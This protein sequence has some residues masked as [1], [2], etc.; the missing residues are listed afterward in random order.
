MLFQPFS[1][2]FK[3]TGTIESIFTGGKAALAPGAGRL[4]TTY[5]DDLIVTSL[6]SG[7]RLLR[8]KG[9]SNAVTCFALKPDASHLSFK[10]HEAPVLAMDFDATS[11]LVATGSADSTVKVWDVD[12][13]YCTHNFRGH[14]GIVSVVKF[15]PD[16]ERLTL[17]SGSD[18]CKICL[19]DLQERTCTAVFSSHVSVIRGLD[20]SPD[21]SMLYSGAR[22][23]V[24][25]TWDLDKLELVKTTPVFESVEALSVVRYTGAGNG[26]THAIC[27]GGDKGI[28]RLWDMQSGELI[29]QETREPNARH[30]IVGIVYDDATGTIVSVT[31]DQNLL[32]YAESS[33]EESSEEAPGLTRVKQI[34]GY[35]EE[36]LDI[37]FVGEEER[38]LAVVTNTEQIRVYDLETRDCDIVY[39]HSDTVLALAASTDGRLV[40][41]GAKDRTA[42]LWRVDMSQPSKDRFQP[43]ATV[44]GHTEPVTAVA[45]SRRA[46]APPSGAT[47]TSAAAGFVITGSQDRTIKVWDL[48]S[49][50]NGKPKARYT[51][52]AH[53]KDIQSVAVAP[54]D[55]MFASAGLDKVAKLWNVA[56]GSLVGTF[57]GHKRGIWCVRFSPVDQVIATTSTDKTIKLWNIHDFSC[58]FEGHLNTVLNV[59]FLSAGMQLMSAGSD[60]LLKVW[61]IKDNECVATLDNHEDRIWGLAV[62]QSESRVVS[63]SS[64]STITLWTDVTVQ[65]KEEQAQED[66]G[67]IVKE[68]DLK[69]FL[70]R[71]DYR[72]AVLLAMQLDQPYRI[73]TILSD[74]HHQAPDA[75]TVTGSRQLDK[76]FKELAPADLERILLYIR[77]WNTN[78]KHVQVTQGLLYLLLRA[79]SPDVITGL[80]KAKEI[81]ESLLPYTERH[82][83]HA[84]EMLKKSQ[85][86]DYTLQCMDNLLAIGDDDDDDEQDDEMVHLENGHNDDADD[87]DL[88]MDDAQ[89]QDDVEDD[90]E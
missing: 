66:A 56:D 74:V 45:V 36:V 46:T 69:L 43:L 14:G 49:I 11:T 28:L 5:G 4:L 82:Y 50:E 35:N 1:N 31:S 33:Q 41:S 2:D 23:K 62:N 78:S 57:K 67:R 9:E 25:N 68:Q 34:A 54:N 6:E 27:T 8:I 26:S 12:R 81:L 39:G 48:K 89:E 18:D 79:Y 24:I 21:G 7:E 73:L 29:F 51:F 53:D 37:S 38:H 61:T 47:F 13:G 15:H 58:T 84:S 75:D 16:P 70:L 30:E 17:V 64:D 77:D 59:W 76:L 90:S 40:I 10:A 63:G 88:D 83:T 87:D 85:V 3:V 42:M 80:P 71:K 65:E 20:F 72:N 19:W 44:A 52:Q 32:F 60:G 55:R 22:D 86:L